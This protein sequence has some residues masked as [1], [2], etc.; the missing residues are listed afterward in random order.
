MSEHE[1]ID[2]KSRPWIDQIQSFNELYR[3][4]E[5]NVEVSPGIKLGWVKGVLIPCLLSTWSVIIFF[6]MPWILGYAGIFHTIIIIFLSLIIILITNLS[7]SA[8][9]TNGK[10]KGMYYFYSVTMENTINHIE[11]T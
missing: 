9:S 3:E 10:I 8:I 4:E 2:I 5:N 11:M 1:E 7:L 6:K